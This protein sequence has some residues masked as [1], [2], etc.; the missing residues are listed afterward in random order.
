MF[1][2]CFQVS[3]GNKMKQIEN[4]LEFDLL[5]IGDITTFPKIDKL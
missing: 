4:P 5:I 3:A 1:L 2:P